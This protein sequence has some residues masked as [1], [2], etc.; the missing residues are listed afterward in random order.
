MNKKEM[1]ELSIKLTEAYKNIDQAWAVLRMM[2]TAT[3]APEAP[4]AWVV[5]DTCSAI[6]DLLADSVLLIGEVGAT[7]EGDI[8]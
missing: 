5:R 7:I 3:D 8:K 2:A 6:E 4:P 1:R